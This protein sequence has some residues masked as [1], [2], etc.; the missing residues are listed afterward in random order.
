MAMFILRC[1][2]PG[3]YGIFVTAVTAIVVLLIAMSGISPKEVMASRAWNTLAGGAI[4]LLAYWV[5]P[6]WER[7]QFSEAMAQALDAYRNYF[8]A[9]R[10]SYLFPGAP[11]VG[12]LDRTRIAGRVARTNVEASIDRLRVEPGT[13]AETVSRFN[14]ILATSLRLAHALM[15]LESGLYGGV[16]APPEET[17]Q[18]FADHVELILSHLAAALRGSPPTVDSLPD[19]REDHRKLVQSGAAA[20]IAVETDRI[21]NSLNTLAEALLNL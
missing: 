9:I 17:F 4:A 18:P 12:E 20:F 6:T 15:A 19:L 7:T 5:W 1:F 3:N 10:S 16:P 21:T 13:S 8:R 2:G 11:A 14:S